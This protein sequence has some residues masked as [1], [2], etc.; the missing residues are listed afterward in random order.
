MGN[1]TQI[2][3]EELFAKHFP[4]TAERLKRDNC[5][6]CKVLGPLSFEDYAQVVIMIKWESTDKFQNYIVPLV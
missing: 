6:D 4:D 2:T 1:K 3:I 5:W